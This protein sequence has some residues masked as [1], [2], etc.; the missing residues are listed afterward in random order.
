MLRQKRTIARLRKKVSH[1]DKLIE[2]L[3]WQTTELEEIGE[4]LHRENNAFISDDEDFLEEMDYEEVDEDKE[5]IDEEES[6][7]A[8]LDDEEEDPE[9]LEYVSDTDAV[10]P[11]VPPQ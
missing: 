5:M 4:D 8:L 6:H 10:V 3:E 1:Q 9:E 11:Q 2:D 7:E